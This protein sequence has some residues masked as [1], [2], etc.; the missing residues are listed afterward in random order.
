MDHFEKLELNWV[1]VVLVIVLVILLVFLFGNFKLDCSACKG[2]G[3]DHITDPFAADYADNWPSNPR[4][5]TM[6]F[7]KR[8]TALD[9]ASYAAYQNPVTWGNKNLGSPWG[10]ADPRMFQ[11]PGGPTM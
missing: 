4:N 7:P 1:T 3:F 6:G 11:Q 2:E 10:A 8:S 9:L 5:Y